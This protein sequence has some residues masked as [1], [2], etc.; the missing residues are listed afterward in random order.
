MHRGFFG[1]LLLFVAA[2][3]VSARGGG[4][5]KWTL[6]H[7]SDGQPDF[8]GYWTNATYTPLERDRELGTKEFFT[9]E[10]AV[11]YAKK[12][13]QVENSQSKDDIHYDNVI[14]QN[15]NYAKIVSRNRT[16]LV[17]DPP[18]GRIPDLTPAAKAIVAAR[19]EYARVHG[20]SDEASSR[21]LGERCISWGNEGPPMLGSTY[22]ANLQF[23]QT[24]G[25]F[26]IRHEI[27]NGVRIIP[28]D[29]TAHVSKNVRLLHGDSRG[30]WES[31]TLVVDTTNF[32]D[33]TPFRGPP[34]TARQ[35]I[36]TSR[37]L[38]VTERFTRVDADTI[39]YRFTVDDPTTFVQPWS[40]EMLMRKMDGPLFEYACHEGNYGLANILSAARVEERRAGGQTAP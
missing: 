40:G 33:R 37:D 29:G 2:T 9:P 34:A 38:R 7:L 25:K 6:A 4:A 8:Q 24:P 22:Q 18:D 39:V 32:S 23:M 10:E 31:D 30:R 11:A 3:M 12:R 21:S 16:S 35:D 26:V 17:F 20:P 13:E 15:E 36:F 14:W 1:I 5:A 28:V 27:M 19:A